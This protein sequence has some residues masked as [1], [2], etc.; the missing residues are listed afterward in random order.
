MIHTKIHHVFDSIDPVRY[1]HFGTAPHYIL[2]PEIVEA[3]SI[4][5]VNQTMGCLVKGRMLNLPHDRLVVERV[6]AR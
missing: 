2:S 4:A 6:C 1:A 3:M 5:E